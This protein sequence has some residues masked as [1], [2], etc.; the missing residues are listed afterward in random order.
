M[1]VYTEKRIDHGQWTIARAGD[2]PDTATRFLNG[3]MQERWATNLWKNYARHYHNCFVDI[4]EINDSHNQINAWYRR[5]FISE[6]SIMAF[7]A[8][9]AQ[10]GGGVFTNNIQIR[11]YDIVDFN[12]PRITK[13][14]GINQ[15]YSVLRGSRNYYPYG[16]NESRYIFPQAATHNWSGLQT[17]VQD[18][19]N[20]TVPPAAP[21][22]YNALQNPEGAIWF[23]SS[24][25]GLYGHPNPTTYVALD[26]GNARG[27]R[28][29]STGSS[30]FEPAPVSFIGAFDLA[31]STYYAMWTG[32]GNWNRLSFSDYEFNV[33]F[34][35]SDASL[36][37]VYS[38]QWVSGATYYAAFIKPVGIDNVIINYYDTSKY[39]LYGHYEAKW[40][41]PDVKQLTPIVND[42]AMRSNSIWVLKN[43]WFW[44]KMQSFP[45][46][47]MNSEEFPSCRFFLRDKNTNLV[48]PYSTSK[49][50]ISQGHRGAN[51][52]AEIKHNA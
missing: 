14:Y 26:G 13:M 49:I 24:K 4:V 41:H 30:S 1:S 12:I 32:T 35:N 21:Y 47:G 17:F 36:I 37:A 27:R 38:I 11:F 15:F 33:Q 43:T 5:I 10:T 16:N 9:V 25:S 29:Y 51:F 50:V 8:S 40:F 52:K 22:T 48:S 44:W 34:R 6:A 28:V 23:P 31:R 20:V 7:C 2:T 18:V 42:G 39:D 46:S 3:N 45:S 19:I